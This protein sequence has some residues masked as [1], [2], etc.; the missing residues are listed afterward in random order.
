MG[1]RRSRGSPPGSPGKSLRQEVNR[2]YG[3]LRQ[4]RRCQAPGSK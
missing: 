2:R 3:F 4:P 1:G